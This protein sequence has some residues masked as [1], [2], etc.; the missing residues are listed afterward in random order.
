MAD[1]QTGFVTAY[2]IMQALY[3]R[4]R[5]GEGLLV[6]SA[7]YDNMLSLNER[8]V[9]LH[10]V[11]GQSPHRGRLRNAYPRSAYATRDG[12]V[13]VNVPEERIWGRLCEVMGRPD[14]AAD[15]R[16]R[17]GPDRAANREFL[18]P[19]FEDLLG[20][21]V[22]EVESLAADGTIGLG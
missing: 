19:I 22:A 18:D 14:L 6:D 15:P 13:A 20:Y 8:M 10:S 1:I 3:L 16:T 21:D 7:L 5:T 4:E 12:Y 9:A 2:G 17:S 11:A